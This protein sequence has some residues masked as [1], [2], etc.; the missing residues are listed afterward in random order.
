MFARGRLRRSGIAQRA[1]HRPAARRSSSP[2]RRRPKP[3]RHAS[4]PGWTRTLLRQQRGRRDW[5]Q[6]GPVPTRSVGPAT[7]PYLRGPPAPSA[8]SWRLRRY[9]GKAAMPRRWSHSTPWRRPCSRRLAPGSDWRAE[10][11]R[12]DRA[13]AG[14]RT[15][16]TTASD[17]RLAHRAE[18]VR[19][20]AWRLARWRCLASRRV[21]SMHNPRAQVACQWQ[22]T[23]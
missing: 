22:C 4:Q 20:I 11:P 13:R 17:H 6:R 14:R 16:T 19:A 8:P 9:P 2:R 7:R 1:P 5:L 21:R 12:S 18:A 23:A 10:P 3:E 15:A